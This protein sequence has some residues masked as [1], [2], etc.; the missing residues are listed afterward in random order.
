M[1]DAAGVRRTKQ[2][3]N[4]R[5]L[6]N[7]FPKS[8]SKI[9]DFGLRWALSGLIGLLSTQLRWRVSRVWNRI[10]RFGLS[11]LFLSLGL[12]ACKNNLPTPGAPAVVIIP[13]NTLAPLYTTTPRYTATLPPSDTPIPT[14]TTPPPPPET[15]TPPTDAPTVALSP[16][17]G[18]QGTINSDATLR[19]GPAKTFSPT[20]PRTLPKGTTLTVIGISSDKKY[21]NVRLDDGVEG[22]IAAN[23]LDVPPDANL[24]VFDPAAQTQ[25]AQTPAG[26]SVGGT[27]P[28][29]DP[30]N[31]DV[32]AYCDQKGRARRTFAQ[33]TAVMV[34]WS[35]Y[36]KTQEQVQAHLDN[37]I[38]DVQ[39]D[40]KSLDN[41]QN[42]HTDIVRQ[43]G[44]LYVYWYVP[45]S[46]DA[47]SSGDHKI[48]YSLTWKAA[49]S[50]GQNDF[51]PGTKQ[52]S[53]TGT[54]G[55]TIK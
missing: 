20:G 15:D 28:Y 13:T 5:F 39:I 1:S 50:D 27:L 17:P 53:N 42:S 35:W 41:W 9:A 25:I 24:T 16:T 36:A 40:G 46:G 19:S 8:R 32:L 48:T 43:Q 23:L 38:Y 33:Q 21:Y 34:W 29:H 47:L 10:R 7:L 51:G 49:I 45:L 6:D 26:L 12:A 3:C 31:S 30:T 54:C 52:E 55:Y 2:L 14:A 37:A 4:R 11:L 44:Q 22:W 18:I